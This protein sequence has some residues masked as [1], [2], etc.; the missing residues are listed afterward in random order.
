MSYR[1]L[2]YPQ[3]KVKAVTLSYDDGVSQDLRL[4]QL[5]DRYGL[6]CT[7]NINSSFVS[8]ISGQPRLSAE[9]LQKYILDAGHEVAVH[10]HEHKAPSHCTDLEIVN[11]VLTCRKALEGPLHTIIRGMA[12]P[13]CGIRRL[14][15]SRYEEVK[16]ILRTLGIAYSRT[17]GEDNNQFFLPND[18]YA[19]MPTAHHDNPQVIAYAE[20][21]AAIDPAQLRTAKLYPRLFY[22][23]GHSYEFDTNDN[24]EHMEKL[25]RILGGREDT[26][27]ATNMEIY[28]YVQAYHALI[29]SADQTRVFNP[30]VYDVWF[31]ENEKEYCVR[32]GET[33]DL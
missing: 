21:F 25:C 24:W 18:W 31:T 22:L 8:D 13:N 29:F 6:K 26:W 23:W 30:T 3:G 4:A 28:Q 5:L 33:L 16:S 15:P 1:F 11:D 9:E 7:F 10:G 32:S 20:E 27:Y 14:S 19:W 17:L 2:R 12:Y